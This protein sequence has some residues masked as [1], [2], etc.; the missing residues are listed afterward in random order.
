MAR[1]IVVL[2]ARVEQAHEEL[3]D[4]HRRVRTLENAQRQT[5]ARVA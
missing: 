5:H 1:K 3:R 2:T 4:L